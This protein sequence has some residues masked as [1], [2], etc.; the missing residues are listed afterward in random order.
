MRRILFLMLMLAA[1][2]VAMPGTLTANRTA[3]AH[4][5]QC[6]DQDIGPDAPLRVSDPTVSTAFYA[7]LVPQDDVDYFTFYGRADQRILLGMTIPQVEGQEDFAPTLA[8]MGPG[9]PDAD[10]PEVIVQPRR[11]G[12]LLIEPPEG[13]AE[14]FYE[15]FSRTSYWERQEEIVTLPANGRYTVAVW[16]AGGDMGHYVFVIGSREIMGGDIECLMN[17][18]RYFTPVEPVAEPADDPA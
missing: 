12:A 11:T 16:H 15:P 2:T 6:E 7:T 14:S 8:L 5:P 3:E 10:L 9:L 1:V 18:D 13:E 4:Q 17:L